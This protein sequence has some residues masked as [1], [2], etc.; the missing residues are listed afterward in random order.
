MSRVVLAGADEELILRVKQAAD[1]D[2][3]VLPPGRLPSDPARLFEQLVDGELPDVLL[4]GPQ[5]PHRR[6]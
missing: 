1:G 2:V 5:R 3:T 4:V 6:S